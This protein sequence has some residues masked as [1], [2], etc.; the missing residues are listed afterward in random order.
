VNLELFGDLDLVAPLTPPGEDE[1]KIQQQLLMFEDAE[2]ISAASNTEMLSSEFQA[3]IDSL[4][5]SQYAVNEGLEDDSVALFS[6]VSPD[7]PAE[8]E[9]QDNDFVS[10]MEVEVSMD[11]AED[12]ISEKILDALLE[13]NLLKAE[14]YMPKTL[15]TATPINIVEITG[16]STSRQQPKKKTSKPRLSSKTDK[17]SR[18][19]EQ[20]KTAATRYREKKKLQATI[21]NYQED[22]L[23]A[24]NDKLATQRDDLKREVLLV[25]QLLR[26]VI[27]AKKL[28]RL[29]K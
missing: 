16:P 9:D 10:L 28:K 20:N 14:S 5:V 26:D 21:V 27:A 15:I 22:E 23:S 6:I 7:T 1:F 19:K 13:G 29:R 25:K 18:K 8:G 11:N 4:P 17:V 3:I 12:H 2:S 24:I